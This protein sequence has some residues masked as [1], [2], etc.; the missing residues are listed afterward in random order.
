MTEKKFK[1]I[2]WLLYGLMAI[3]AL[4]TV[5]FYLNPS[6]PDIL[7]YWGYA[8]VIFSLVVVLAVSINGMLK[9]PKGS[10]KV[11]VI[12]GGM[13]V[14]AI[15]SYALSK[16]TL[17]PNEMEKYSISASGVKM[18]GAGLMM[19]YIIGIIAIGVLLYTSLYRFFK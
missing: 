8:L 11:L 18:V 17:S 1:L 5:I 7:L 10:Y 2:Q 13:I 14:L 16:N 15:L 19:T 9:N 4:F 3:S 12:L 6:S